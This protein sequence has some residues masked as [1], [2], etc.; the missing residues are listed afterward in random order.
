MDVR[1]PPLEIKILLESSPLKSRILVRRWAVDAFAH[2]RFTNP[3]EMSYMGILLILPS[4]LYFGEKPW[5]STITLNFTPP[6]R[7]Y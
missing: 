4:I 3:S 2:P 6:A 5:F 7:S 1:I